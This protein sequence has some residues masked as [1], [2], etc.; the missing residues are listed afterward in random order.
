MTAA[1][2][3]ERA[4]AIG[5]IVFDHPERRN[6]LTASMI[7]D[8][9]AALSEAEHDDA[10]RVIV[11]RGAGEASFVSGA[12]ISAFGSG[13]DPRRGASSIADVTAA[14]GASAKPVVAALRGWCLG[15]GVL[16]ALEADLRV[17]GDDVRMGIPAAKLGIGYSEGGVARLVTLAGPSVAL[18]LLMSGDPLDAEQA[19]QAGLVNRVVPAADLFDTVTSLAGRL[20]GNA[21]LTLVAAKRA[22]ASVLAPQDRDAAARS[23]AAIAACFKSED[24]AEGQRAFAEKRRPVFRGR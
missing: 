6:A 12:D 3:L 10:I 1:V 9:A 15:A 17:A 21:P 8:A 2:R 20:A 11:L 19:R 18:E 7:D 14:M 22:V 5:W 13:S 23:A 16:L 24:F 4:G